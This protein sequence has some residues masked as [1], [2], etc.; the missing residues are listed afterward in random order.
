MYRI[1][2]SRTSLNA[3]ISLHVVPSSHKCIFFFLTSSHISVL[4]PSVQLSEQ[5]F[6]QAFEPVEV[7]TPHTVS[8]SSGDPAVLDPKY[9]ACQP[10]RGLPGSLDMSTPPSPRL[11][12]LLLC[13]PMKGKCRSLS[14]FFRHQHSEILAHSESLLSEFVPTNQKTFPEAQ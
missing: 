11:S 8:A 10:L 14:L 7:L 2:L 12:H 3:Q 6:S 4:D 5:S 9:E 13:W 1:L